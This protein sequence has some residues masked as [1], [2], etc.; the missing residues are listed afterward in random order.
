MSGV[1]TTGAQT[2]PVAY[3]RSITERSLH[4]TVL[5]NAPS[6]MPVR[7]MSYE[8]ANLWLGKGN[9]VWMFDGS[10]VGEPFVLEDCSDI[11]RVIARPSSAIVFCADTLVFEVSVSGSVKARPAI[12]PELQKPQP[13]NSRFVGL[14]GGKVL[15][16]EE[17]GEIDL[18][19][20]VTFAVEGENVAQE[21]DTKSASAVLPTDGVLVVTGASHFAYAGT[22]PYEVVFFGLDGNARRQRIDDGGFPSPAARLKEQEELRVA[23]HSTDW[24]RG[25]FVVGQVKTTAARY[26]DGRLY[27]ERQYPYR[28]DLIGGEFDGRMSAGKIFFI[29]VVHPETGKVETRSTLDARWVGIRDGGALVY[30]DRPHP[31]KPPFMTV[32]KKP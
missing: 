28:C 11:R 22:D 4:R 29:D 20:H 19:N 27:I 3:Q 8:G 16:T 15:L 7:A 18:L 1:A 26:S 17:S 25:N 2:Q 14:R 24:Q 30:F 9:S 5:T 23:K 12:P 13:F 10:G 6:G 31:R 21:G 32:A